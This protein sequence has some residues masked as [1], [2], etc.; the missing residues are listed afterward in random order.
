MDAHTDFSDEPPVALEPRPICRD[1]DDE[2]DLSQPDA[3]RDA[4]LG[5]CPR[6]GAWF[7]IAP[8]ADGTHVSHLVLRPA[9]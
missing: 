5:V 7:T 8:R 6:C 1:C 4:L 2:L 3:L 9:G